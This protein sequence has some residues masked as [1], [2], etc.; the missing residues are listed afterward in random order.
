M[1]VCILVVPILTLLQ[2]AHLRLVPFQR[3]SIIDIERRIPQEKFQ[4]TESKETYSG[5]SRGPDASGNIK[6]N[7]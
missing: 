6:T 4:S 5:R 7:R 1:L 3:V 2:V